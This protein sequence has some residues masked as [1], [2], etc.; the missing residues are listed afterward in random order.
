[1]AIQHPFT[2]DSHWRIPASARRAAPETRLSGYA[3]LYDATRAWAERLRGHAS[4]MVFASLGL[5]ALGGVS[6]APLVTLV[7][8]VILLL[9]GGGPARSLAGPLIIGSVIWL[10]LAILCAHALHSD[11]VSSGLE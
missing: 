8:L 10:A 1:M 3:G 4:G 2:S 11:H 9:P 6:V 5:V 7:A